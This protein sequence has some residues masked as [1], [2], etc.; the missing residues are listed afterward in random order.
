MTSPPRIESVIC[1]FDVRVLCHIRFTARTVAR[2]Q[3]FINETVAM[4]RGAGELDYPKQPSLSASGSITFSSEGRVFQVPMKRARLPPHAE[5]VR[6]NSR[7]RRH[8]TC[9]AN[10]IRPC[11]GRIR[12]AAPRFVRPLQGRQIF[13]HSNRGRCPRL[14]NCSLSGCPFTPSALTGSIRL[15]ASSALACVRYGWR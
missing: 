6:F 12:F 10:P 2:P 14:L 7:W 11:K 1:P 8:R 5:G 13:P 9:P 4:H 15:P 3:R